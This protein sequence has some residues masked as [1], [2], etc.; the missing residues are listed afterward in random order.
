ML[1]LAETWNT[2]MTN[3]GGTFK[4]G[5]HTNRGELLAGPETASAD[6]YVRFVL[7]SS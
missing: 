2:F 1:G 3:P 6:N 5:V 4:F 7:G